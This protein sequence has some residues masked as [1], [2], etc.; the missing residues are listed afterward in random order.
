[1]NKKKSNKNWNEDDRDVAQLIDEITV[2]AY[3]DDEKLWAFRQVIEDE[4]NLP[5]DGFVMD[6]PVEV[7]EID[8]DGNERRG[9]TAT[10]RRPNGSKHL[11]AAADVM[12]P[13]NSAAARYLDAYRKWLGLET[14]RMAA[15]RPGRKPRHKAE[16]SDLKHSAWFRFGLKTL[17]SGIL[18]SITGEMRE[19]HL[20]IGQSRLFRAVPVPLLSWSR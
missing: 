3:T 17:A 2:D 8:Y 1:M 4:V 5:A 13:K 9:L 6:E 18:L 11:V 12:F 7:L 16:G 15:P 14:Y 20:K 19:N 10:C